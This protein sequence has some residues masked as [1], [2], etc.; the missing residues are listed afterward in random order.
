MDMDNRSSLKDRRRALVPQKKSRAV[1]KSFSVQVQLARLSDGGKA[2]AGA[3]PAPVKTVSRHS[4]R[5]GGRATAVFAL[6]LLLAVSGL[7]IRLLSGPISFASL[8]PTLERKLNSQLQGYSFKIGDAILRLASDWG[9]EFRLADVS[10]VDEYNQEIAKAPFAALDVSE[11]SLFKFALA[12]SQIELIGPK[13]LIFNLP[14]KGFTLTA[15]APN[16]SA[17]WAPVA[18]PPFATATEATQSAEPPEIAG[19][20]RMAQQ[21][22]HARPSAFPYN[23]APFLSRL[24]AA[25]EKRDGASLALKR[26]GLKDATIYFANSSGVSTWRVDDFH[27]DLSEKRSASA[28]SGY[29]TIQRE[30]AT[31]RASFRAVDRR[32]EKRYLLTASVEDV[33]P[34]DVWR[35]VPSVGALKIVDAPVSGEARFDI[36]HDGELL[37]GE[38]DI[39]LGGGR[40]FAPFDEKHPA[41]VEQGTLKVA[42]DKANES[43]IV[44]P[45][46]L[47]WDDSVLSIAGAIAHRKDPRT[48]HSL[49][50]AALD[51]AGTKLAAP[52]FAVLPARIDS[53]NIAGDYDAT[54]DSLSL[55]DFHIQ[56]GRSRL[57]FAVKASQIQSGGDLSMSGSA[58]PMPIAFLKAIWPGF[59][60]HGAREW[61]GLNVPS[62]QITGATFSL[63][64]SG[65]ELA[66]V[67]NG[68]DVP[69]GAFSLR[70]G[71][72][73]AQIYHIRGLPPIKTKDSALRVS[74]QRFVYDIPEDA[75]IETPNGRS[76]ALSNGQLIITNL[77]AYDPDAEIY[78]QGA[79]EVASVLE[80]L[81]QPPL[82][83]VKAVGFKP[84]LV[85]GQVQATFQIKFPI[86]DVLTFSLFKIT[87]K[88]RVSDLRSNSLPGGLAVNGGAVNFDVLE[89]AISANGEVKVNNAPVSV[90]WQRFFDAP[91]EK[92]PTL[93]LA[94]ILT[95]KA[96]D[97][98]GLNVNHIVKGDL[99]VA[100]AVALQKN[101]PPRFFMEANLTNADI[102]LTAIGWRKSPGQKASVTFDVS[103]RPDN[104]FA[105][106]NFAM[107]GDGL[108]V[109]GRLL[110]NDNHRIAGFAFPEFSTNALTQ[111]SISGE[112]TP[113]NVLKVQAKGASYD[114]RQFFRSL[115]NAGKIADNQP[116][117]P[118]DEPGLDL[119]VEIETLFGYYDTSVKSVR[120]DAKRRG[121]KLT[122]LEVA[123]R[124][125]G[126]AP[127]AVHVEQRGGEA[128][129]LVS[130]ATDAGSAFRLVGF[131]AAMR[132]GAMNLRVNLDGG[133]G[134]DKTGVLD[135][136]RFAVAGDQVVGRVVSQAE[137]E[138]ARHKPESR[139]ASQFS[140]EAPLQFDRMVVPFSVG[141]N[142]FQLHDAAINGPLIGATLRGRIDFGHETLALSGTYVPLYGFNA[143]LGAVPLLGDLLKGRENE[144]IFGITF[145]VQGRTS[146]PDVVVNPVSMLAP[147]FLRQIFE[148]ENAAPQPAPQ[149]TG[150]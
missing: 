132:G 4:I 118:K 124:L 107:T 19:V 48:G 58:S 22:L 84:N 75:R 83:Y 108:N 45:F 15:E 21:A 50:S 125:N 148:F 25:L 34:R 14:G 68:R 98:L 69:D 114:G 120:I 41:V 32:Q 49:W 79:G 81:D 42:Y 96:R 61:V 109:K 104:F 88:S 13:V 147:G 43:I 36:S 65:R 97:D 72:S 111:L 74:G 40:L 101:G 17:G 115:L 122:Y 30:D 113:Q 16:S 149:R 146:N 126:E 63:N 91:P 24:F 92:Q 51:G 7:Y 138:G 82:G 26:I 131:Y 129:M 95:E 1:A 52:Q 11:R 87:G 144:G 110:L 60:A 130:D 3:I 140:T 37:S 39:K 78:F 80:L 9:L 73:G 141:A 8:V 89:N 123:G 121:G 128:R 59:L 136:R 20:R 127:V 76:I 54:A 135:V 100:L 56:S 64:L 70:V 77:R 67:N 150:G 33:V 38:A 6:V 103:Q 145:A 119:N 105:L 99:P 29:L 106:D 55:N 66:E 112:L 139:K 94:S 31:W 62:A 12:A 28:L 137:R 71:V 93:R 44:K 23:P 53:L 5:F 10:V 35:G 143:V 102:F 18:A 117:P 134:A 47:R 27:I 2:I 90:A 142:Q 85:N 116:A 86:A 133:G 46:E 57:E